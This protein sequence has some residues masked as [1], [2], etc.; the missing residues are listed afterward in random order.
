M[1]SSFVKAWKLSVV[2][3]RFVG[4]VAAAATGQVWHLSYCHEMKQELN[5][6]AVAVFGVRSCC[7]VVISR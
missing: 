5:P 7:A 2:A 1:R 3:F 6:F 4:Q